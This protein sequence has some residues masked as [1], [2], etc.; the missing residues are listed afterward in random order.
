MIDTLEK[1]STRPTA[2]TL[3][4][5]ATFLV[6]GLAGA[7]LGPTL[8]GLAEHTGSRISEISFLFATRSL[9]YLLGSLQS[10]RLFDRAPG[11]P[12]IAGALVVASL[13]L[14][15]VPTL[16]LLWV[17]TAIL[18]LLGFA[19]SIIDLGGNILLVW[20]YGA[21]VGPLMN[22]LHLFFGVGAFLSPIIVA[23][24]RQRS[25]D[26]NWAYWILAIAALPVAFWL[27]RAPS[28]AIPATAEKRSAAP[29]NYLPVAL[30]TLLIFL[31]VGA[32]VSFGGWVFTYATALG[33]SGPT[34]AAYLTSAFWGALMLGRLAGI[35]L[36]SRFRPSQIL[37]TDLV[38]CL[39][40]MGVILGWPGSLL[41]LGVGALGLGFSMASI[42]PIAMALA[43]RRMLVTGSTTRW[44]FFGAGAGAVVA[45]WTIGQLFEGVGPAVTMYAITIALVLALG[46]LMLLLRFTAHRRS[47]GPAQVGVKS[48][49]GCGRSVTEPPEV[50]PWQ[51]NRAAGASSVRRS[52]RA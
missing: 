51:P 46:T 13:A 24:A 5:Y 27:L 43:E 12:V 47:T 41:A 26:I 1:S 29:V 30:F 8:P 14:A 52:A 2:A 21:R 11:H 7:V 9:G 37:F 38:G 50:L 20:T 22:G 16:S 25:Q 4:Y 31:Y 23:Q 17:L 33:L 42:F 40:S 44:L 3:A 36:A 34:L 6:L 10:G 15:I 49:K 45:P 48:C 19:E 18:F 35:P 32:E 39:I 28:P